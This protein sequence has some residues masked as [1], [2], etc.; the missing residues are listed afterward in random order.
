MGVNITRDWRLIPGGAYILGAY[1][2]GREGY[3][4]KGF[5]CYK[6]DGPIIGGTYISGALMSRELI[7]RI[8]W[9]TEKQKC[10]AGS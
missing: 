8:L 1:N 7:S 9:Y 6:T 4:R 2:R 10:V 3:N 5:F